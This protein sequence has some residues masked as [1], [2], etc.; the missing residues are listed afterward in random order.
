MSNENAPF[1]EARHAASGTRRRQ[2]QAGEQEGTGQ[3]GE[4][5]RRRQDCA[6]ARYA[7]AIP[8]SPGSEEVG[9]LHV[10]RAGTAFA[11]MLNDVGMLSPTGVTLTVATR[12]GARRQ[13]ARSSVND[14]QPTASGVEKLTPPGRAS[15]AA[16]ASVAG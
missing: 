9:A 16:G 4:T 8:S 11:V 5:S 12:T 13:C 1:A 3:D 10:D 14:R 15:R 7:N 2:R 6:H